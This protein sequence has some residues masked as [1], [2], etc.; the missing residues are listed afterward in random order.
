MALSTVSDVE[1][2]LGVDLSSNDESNVTSVFIKAAD[3]AIENYVGYGL[4]YQASIT[5]KF[6]GNDD[7]SIYLKHIPVV[8]VTSIVEDGV[9][10]TEGN[11]EDYVVY[12][13]QGLVKELDY[14]IG[15]LKGYKIL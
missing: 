5:E 11:D 6:D 13:K 9:T 10:L 4:D 2:V 12:T 3:A 8:S 7:D 15:Q 14:N 1:K